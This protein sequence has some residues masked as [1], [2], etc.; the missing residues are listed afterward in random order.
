MELSQAAFE[1]ICCFNCKQINFPM[2]ASKK[3]KQS[4]CSNCYGVDDSDWMFPQILLE[5]MIKDC[6]IIKCQYGNCD[7]LSTWENLEKHKEICCQRPILCPVVGC[8]DE[9]INASSIVK[10]FTDKH[11]VVDSNTFKVDR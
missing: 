5:E 2:Y 10:H 9:N 6:C 7:Y 11:N 1:K 8:Q 3:S 4:V